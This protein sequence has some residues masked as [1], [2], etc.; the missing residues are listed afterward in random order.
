MLPSLFDVALSK[1]LMEN[2]VLHEAAVQEWDSNAEAQFTTRFVLFY[3][4]DF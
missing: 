2:S 4:V 3:D 1:E